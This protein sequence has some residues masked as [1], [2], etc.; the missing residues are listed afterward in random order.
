METLLQKSIFEQFKIVPSPKMMIFSILLGSGY[1]YFLYNYFKRLS[2]YAELND[3]AGFF[4]FG[5]ISITSFILFLIADVF[6]RRGVIRIDGEEVFISSP[7]QMWASG[8]RE[9][10]EMKKLEIEK[11]TNWG[12]YIFRSEGKRTLKLKIDF[13]QNSAGAKIR[14]DKFFLMKFADARYYD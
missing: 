11:S 13:I 14:P 1:I 5:F 4:H 2:E 6:K 7:S 10:Y 8:I 3:K 12:Y 9:T